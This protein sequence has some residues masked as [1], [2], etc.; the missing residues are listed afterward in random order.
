MSVD[1]TVDCA[2]CADARPR[3]MPTISMCAPHSASIACPHITKELRSL[4]QF[5]VVL[6]GTLKCKG[7]DFCR[8]TRTTGEAGCHGV[9]TKNTSYIL[10]HNTYSTCAH[11]QP[12]PH[13]L[14]MVSP[15]V[16]CPDSFLF[17]RLIRSS[18]NVCSTCLDMPACA[19][20][21]PRIAIRSIS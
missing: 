9:N 4:E 1:R 18:I 17:M 12:Q 6:S 21:S 14:L 20:S 8:L 2:I 5:T 3:C 11:A 13:Q 10:I 7:A 19:L 16:A 15:I